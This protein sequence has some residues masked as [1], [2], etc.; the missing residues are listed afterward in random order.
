[1]GIIFVKLFHT[2]V[3]RDRAQQCLL[4]LVGMV[5][6]YGKHYSTFFFHSKMRSWISFDD[7]TVTDVSSDST[8]LVYFS[9]PIAD[10]LLLN[11]TNATECWYMNEVK[12]Y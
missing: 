11:E 10:L 6:Y 4:N 1:M 5:C 12:N 2:I 8:R 9:Q 7:A 3:D